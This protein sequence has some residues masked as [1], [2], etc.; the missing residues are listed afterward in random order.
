MPNAAGSVNI[1]L[2]MNAVTFTQGIKSA[3]AELDKFAGKSKAAGHST[4]SSM[5]AAS[6]SIREMNGNFANNTRA[7][8]RFITTI[9]GVGNVLKAAFPIVGG[10]AFGAMISNKE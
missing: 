2:S 6:A 9:P 10:L 1:N 5:Q 3:Q 8:E 7:V 4:V